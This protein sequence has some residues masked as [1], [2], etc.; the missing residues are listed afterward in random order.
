MGVK[1]KWDAFLSS[2]IKVV[3]VFDAQKS[4]LQ[5]HSEGDK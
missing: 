1:E 5:S 4:G 3:V 2:G